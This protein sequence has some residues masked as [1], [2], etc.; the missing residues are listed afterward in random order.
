MLLTEKDLEKFEKKVVRDCGYFKDE[1]GEVAMLGMTPCYD[2]GEGF[3]TDYKE[4]R[5]SISHYKEKSFP[6]KTDTDRTMF[7][8]E[9]Y[10]KALNN[11]YPIFIRFGD[12]FLFLN[13]FK[14]TKPQKP[15]VKIKAL[16]RLM[17]QNVRED[18]LVSAEA[19]LYELARKN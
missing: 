5:E 7:L 3:Y 8:R 19:F 6:I 10:A 14:F 17:N 2:L 9:L 13:E 1:R 15:K 12:Q 16:K 4:E 11:A 18:K